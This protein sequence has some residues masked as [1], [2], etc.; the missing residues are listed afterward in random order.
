MQEPRMALSAFF[1]DNLTIIGITKDCFLER[2]RLVIHLALSSDTATCPKCCTVSDQ[3]HS[4]RIKTAQDLPLMNYSV[5]IKLQTR[6]FSCANPDCQQSI[7]IERTEPFIGFYDR[8]T[9]R[10]QD[11]VLQL[12][13]NSSCESAASI[14]AYLGIKISPDTLLNMLKKKAK[15]IETSVG[16]I[17]GIDDWAYRRST[18]Y[19]TIICDLKSHRIVDVIEGRTSDDLANWLKEHPHITMVS[20]DRATSYAH[21]VEEVLPNAIQIA[22]RFH[23]T[24]NLLDALKKTMK[25]YFPQQIE[26]ED[27]IQKPIEHAAE[28]EMIN[29]PK[30]KRGRKSTKK[31]RKIPTD[32]SNTETKSA[33]GQI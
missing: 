20:R 22:D 2:E 6:R 19:G 25:A 24:K 12:A 3:L 23:I 26:I 17:I 9:K 8:M 29:Q 30:K 13:I 21:A 15:T 31:R 4:T 28:S 27:E 5:K 18:R 14:C 16:E 11:F 33:R 7:F 32:Y 1:P 10:C